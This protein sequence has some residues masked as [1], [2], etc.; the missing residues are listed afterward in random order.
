VDGI[1]FWTKNPLPML[2]RLKEIDDFPYYFLFTLNPY[3]TPLEGN[4]PPVEVSV[5]TLYV[6][7][8]RLA[9][10]GHLEI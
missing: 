3:G 2:H 5:D 1:V 7:P 4:V 9:R 6:C 10:E 8:S